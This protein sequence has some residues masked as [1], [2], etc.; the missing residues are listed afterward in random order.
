MAVPKII[1]FKPGCNCRMEFLSCW[2]T[3]ILLFEINQQKGA[4][5][6]ELHKPKRTMCNS[7]FLFQMI[8]VVISIYFILS[9]LIMNR[10]IRLRSRRQSW[11]TLLI[12]HFFFSS[13]LLEMYYDQYYCQIADVEIK[14]HYRYRIVCIVKDMSKHHP[15]LSLL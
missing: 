6:E 13:N 10:K 1:L 14:I 9:K 2:I 7:G 5:L 11:S 15:I 3:S 4:P 12:F 8:L